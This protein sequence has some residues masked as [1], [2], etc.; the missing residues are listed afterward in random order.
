M[1]HLWILSLALTLT[2]AALV[3][4]TD[5]KIMRKLGQGDTSEVDLAK[6]VEPKA[7][8]AEVKAFAKRMIEDHSR[9]F[10]NL[11]KIAKEEKVKLESGMDS[12]H[13]KFA[14]E[15][16][17]KRLGE[18]YDRTYIEQMV[19]DHEHDKS[20]VEKALK[21]IKDDELKRWAENE[22]TTIKEHL[23]MAEEIRGKVK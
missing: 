8:N 15:L 22:L 16:A 5:H 21:E 7:T 18:E 4:S 23:K 3:T 10:E 20:E 12:E 13:K 6:I 1:K 14:A 11:E 19:K 2:A 9:A 17:K